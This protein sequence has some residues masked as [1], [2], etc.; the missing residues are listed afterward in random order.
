MTT[1]L[2][3]LV[4]ACIVVV[5]TSK[6]HAQD[7]P[8]VDFGWSDHPSMKIGDVRLEVAAR[9]ETDARMAAPAVGRDRGELSWGDPRVEV[10]GRVTRRIDFEVSREFGD[11]AS[12]KDAFLNIRVTRAL[13]IE[14]GRF[15]IPFG[16]ET[17]VGR[18]NLDFIHRSLGASQLAPSRDAGVMVHGQPAA[19]MGKDQSFPVSIEVQ[20]LGGDDSGKRSTGNLCTPGTN[21]EMGGK[22]HT[23]HCT[24]STSANIAGDVW[25]QAEI[26]VNKGHVRHYINGKLVLEY[27]APQYDPTDADAKRL[28]KGD[29][30]MIKGGTI[31]LQSE[32]HPI[33]F[34]KIEVMSL[35]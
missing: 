14:A 4:C 24:N 22:L 23:Q 18:A 10:R 31:S 29:N 20:F 17:L 25:V 11:D 7:W 1:T 5:V 16:R 26:E 28:I 21:V 32:S 34:R 3:R 33:E 19:S 8:A 12:W 2:G 9:A 27:D 15:K 6:A 35:D 30:L 13:E